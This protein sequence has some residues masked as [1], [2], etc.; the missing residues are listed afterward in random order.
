MTA[1]TT[2][3]PLAAAAEL[4]VLV[5]DVVGSRAGEFDRMGVVPTDALLALGDVGAWGAVVPRAQGGTG[6][7]FAAFGALHEEVGRCCSSVRSLLTVH[8]MV[9]FAVWRWAT[10]AARQR[11]FADL[12]RGSRLGAFC[13]TEPEAGSDIAGLQATATR[14][15]DGYVLNG[16][17]RWITGGQA[18]DVFLVFARAVPGGVT[19]FLVDA[20]HPGVRRTPIR[21]VLG[22][23]ASMLAD[24]EF[25]DCAIGPDA[26]VGV[27][28]MGLPAATGCLDIGRYSVACGCVGIIQACLEASVRHASRRRQGGAYLSDRQLVQRMIAGMATSAQ[29]ARL[30]CRH[31]GVLKDRSDPGTVMA[32][33]IAKYFAADAAMRASSDAVQIHGAVGCAEDAPVARYF[34]DAKVME[35]IEGATQIQEILIAQDACRGGYGSEGGDD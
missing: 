1:G 21:Q 4:R 26:V 24:V 27:P 23:R 16:R 7:G 2:A 28:G 6:D 29:A 5:E 22:T 18:A 34:R 25:S 19:A 12:V 31:A 35:I 20:A 17:K 9:L 13:L 11:W 15:P 10:A 30:L 32:T 8:S 3:G 14:S 33:C